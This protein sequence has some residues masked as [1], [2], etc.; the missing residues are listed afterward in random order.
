LAVSTKAKYSAFPSY[1]CTNGCLA[2]SS[3]FIKQELLFASKR[4][5][6]RFE[7]SHPILMFQNSNIL[8][9]GNLMKPALTRRFDSWFSTVLASTIR[10]RKRITIA[11][12]PA[13]DHT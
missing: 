8:H 11:V 2:I 5:V 12:W 4:K 13:S 9:A 7:F 1:C 3:D 6:H 10:S